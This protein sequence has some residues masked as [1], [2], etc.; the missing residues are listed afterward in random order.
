MKRKTSQAPKGSS[1]SNA[2]LNDNSEENA[3][4]WESD[5]T[6]NAVK[7]E[8]QPAIPSFSENGMY[9]KIY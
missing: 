6:A 7:V 5:P 1:F 3:K 8:E 4:L 9:E 2:T